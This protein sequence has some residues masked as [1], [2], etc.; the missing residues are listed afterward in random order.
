M[1]REQKLEDVLRRLVEEVD[2][3]NSYEC[4]GGYFNGTAE[5]LNP[6]LEA[7]GLPTVEVV[8]ED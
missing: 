3:A 6:L 4:L 7:L 8:E 2:V 1:S 5:E